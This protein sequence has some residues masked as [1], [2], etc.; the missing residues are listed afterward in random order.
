MDS[1]LVS[2]SEG[3]SIY[4]TP[5]EQRIIT[6]GNDL[7]YLYYEMYNESVTMGVPMIVLKRVINTT[8]RL[9]AGLRFLPPDEPLATAEPLSEDK[10]CY[11]Q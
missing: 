4:K 9:S 1:V 5:L 7:S 10:R 2:C 11:L 8:F 6:H 3:I